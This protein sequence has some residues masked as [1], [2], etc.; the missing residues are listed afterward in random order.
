MAKL[1]SAWNY[2]PI[3]PGPDAWFAKGDR[4]IYIDEP[5]TVVGVCRSGPTMWY[6]QLDSLQGKGA[7][8]CHVNSLERV[9]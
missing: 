6:V 9:S 4:V 3:D 7:T 5:G 8:R 2:G 1:L